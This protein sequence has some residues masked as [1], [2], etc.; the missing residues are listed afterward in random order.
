MRRLFILVLA[1]AA[2][3]LAATACGDDAP[4]EI[5]DSAADEL[6]EPADTDADDDADAADG[7]VVEIEL[8]MGDMYFEPDTIEV[9][10]GATVEFTLENVGDAEHDLV[11]ENEGESEIAQPGETI[12]FEAGP[13][14][15]D[16]V[17]WCSVPGHRE[18]GMELDVVVDG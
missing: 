5:D 8:E 16:T 14:D 4:D 18:A 7:D 15:E 3:A 11:F 1:L 17:G 9:P 6:D 2:L 13:F 10:S 12:T